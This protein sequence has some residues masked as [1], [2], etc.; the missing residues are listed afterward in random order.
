MI[1]ENVTGWSELINGNVT[2]AAFQA[3][4]VPLGGSLILI[5]YI[6]LSIVLWVRTQSIELCTIMSF[7]FLGVFLTVPWFTKET[8]GIA[9]I[10]TVF[11][12][13]A[14]IYKFIAKEKNY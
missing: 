8:I 6:V 11:E 3:L 7:I 14:T 13:G 10:I 12:L 4:N 5:L 2:G 1:I 9:I